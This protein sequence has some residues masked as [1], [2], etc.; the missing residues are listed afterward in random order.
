VIVLEGALAIGRHAD[1]LDT[2]EVSTR[3]GTAR[4]RAKHATSVLEESLLA[5]L[6]SWAWVKRKVKVS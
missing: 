4:S 2:A 6:T 1:P 5:L 3:M